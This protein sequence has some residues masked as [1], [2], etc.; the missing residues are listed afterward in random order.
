MTMIGRREEHFSRIT[1][2]NKEKKT[3]ETR[4]DSLPLERRR[5]K[6][7]FSLVVKVLTT[8]V[9]SRLRFSGNRSLSLYFS[10]V[11]HCSLCFIL[12]P[13]PPFDR[14]SLLFTF[15]RLLVLMLQRW[16][17][18]QRWWRKEKITR[19]PHSRHQTHDTWEGDASSWVR[20]RISG[21]NPRDAVSQ[22]IDRL[23]FIFLVESF[24]FQFTSHLCRWR[25]C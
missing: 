21:T 13:K 23:V 22:W 6:D 15:G 9:A 2:Q 20:R 19:Y 25:W 11:F 24:P 4:E 14:L 10:L 5:S 17:R 12:L 8:W 3:Q 1:R 7:I 16:Q 18:C